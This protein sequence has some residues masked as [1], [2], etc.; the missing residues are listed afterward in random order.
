MLA[1]RRSIASHRKAAAKAAAAASNGLT[2][3][4]GVPVGTGSP[5]SIDAASTTT[6]T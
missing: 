6:T 2:D 5:P 3:E 4:A 1:V